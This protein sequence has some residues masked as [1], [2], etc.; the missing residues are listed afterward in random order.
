M[1][2]GLGWNRCRGLCQLTIPDSSPEKTLPQLHPL[3]DVHREPC[4]LRGDNT[5]LPIK[6][7]A[8]TKSKSARQECVKIC[9]SCEHQSAPCTHTHKHTDTHRTLK[10][11]TGIAKAV[12]QLSC[13]AGSSIGQGPQVVPQC[14]AAAKLEC[15]VVLS[16]ISLKNLSRI[17]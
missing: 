9:E 12:Q 14:C 1:K 5:R 16:W 3:N 2:A 4:L 13:A 10:C 17:A 6:P 15:E 8:Q 7:S 11:R